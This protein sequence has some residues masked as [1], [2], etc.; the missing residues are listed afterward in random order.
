MNVFLVNVE[1]FP[2][3]GLASAT[4]FDFI[5]VHLRPLARG[6]Y[7]FRTQA[8]RPGKLLDTIGGQIVII[9]D[10]F[11]PVS[12]SCLHP[13]IDSSS[14]TAVDGVA[15]VDEARSQTTDISFRLIRRT[16]ICYNYLAEYYLRQG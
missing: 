13:S 3:S 11:Y 1:S 7:C 10:E 14:M 9:I 4:Q 5:A 6:N 8:D 2:R 15:V 16:V 12:R